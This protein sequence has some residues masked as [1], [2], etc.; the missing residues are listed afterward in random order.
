MLAKKS[1]ITI[2]TAGTTTSKIMLFRSPAQKIL[3]GA[4]PMPSR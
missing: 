3:S 2:V 4:A 1:E